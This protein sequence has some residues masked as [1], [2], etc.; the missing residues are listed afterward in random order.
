M[1]T[2]KREDHPE[3]TLALVPRAGAVNNGATPPILEHTTVAERG[4]GRPS[5]AEKSKEE[6]VTWRSLPHKGQLAVLTMARLSE[7]LVQTSLQV[8]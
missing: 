4:V 8:N 1:N 7:P 6:L 2:S 5:E 3:W